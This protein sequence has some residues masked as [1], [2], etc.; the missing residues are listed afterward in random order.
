MRSLGSLG[1]KPRGWQCGIQRAG[2]TCQGLQSWDPPSLV[3]IGGLHGHVSSSGGCEW[4][5]FYM[6]CI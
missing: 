3:I 2:M 6:C 1:K 5:L 4:V